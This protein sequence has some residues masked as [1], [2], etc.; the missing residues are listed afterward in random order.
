[1][2]KIVCM[3]LLFLWGA[4]PATH[5]EFPSQGKESVNLKPTD[6]KRLS[7]VESKCTT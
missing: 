7:A 2:L 3:V 1:M 4:V 5:A 6:E